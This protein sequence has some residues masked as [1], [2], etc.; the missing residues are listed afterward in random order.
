[1]KEKIIAE[2]TRRMNEAYEEVAD[3]EALMEKYLDDGERYRGAEKEMNT[4][5]GRATAL[6]ELLLWIAL[7]TKEEN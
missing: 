4:A 3:Y 6:D 5:L 2:I 7:N 1:M